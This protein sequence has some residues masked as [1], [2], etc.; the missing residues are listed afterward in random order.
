MRPLFIIGITATLF[1]CAPSRYVKPL[2]HKQHAI[3]ATLGGAMLSVPGIGTI[4]LPNTSLGYGYGATEEMTVFG[5][6]YS[7]AAVFGDIQ[8]D[9]GCSYRIWKNEKMGVTVSPSVNFMVDVFEKNARIWPQLDAN[10]YFDYWNKPGKENSGKNKINFFYAGF[11]NWFEL[12]GTRAHEL[13][14]PYR[15]LFN[16]Q[17]GHTFQRGKWDFNLEAKFLVP[18]ISNEKIVVDYFSPFG[19]RGGLGAYFGVNYKL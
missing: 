14:Q 9:A 4:P 2:E 11:S 8:L 16:P 5:N 3:S 15:L 18:Y 7:T 1:A 13:E 17:I 6:W 19:N 10:Y 12:Q